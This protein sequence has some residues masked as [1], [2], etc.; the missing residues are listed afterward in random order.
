VQ[1]ARQT[2]IDFELGES[3]QAAVVEICRLLDGIPLAIELAAAWV[4]MLSF[5]EIAREI[6]ANI[7]F[8][9]TAARDVPERHRSLIASFDHSWQFL[10]GAERDSLCRLSIFEGGFTRQAAESVAG[11]K[12]DVLASLVS[13]SLVRRRRTGRYDMHEAIRQY[14][15]AR[16]GADAV[17]L[18]ST[19]DRHCEY[20]MGLVAARESALKSSDQQVAM[21]ELAAEMDNIRAAWYWGIQARK[22]SLLGASVRGL[23]W[24]FEVSGLL[25]EGIDQL[26][27]FAQQIRLDP[28]SPD[29]R[30]ALGHTLAQQALLFFRRGQF[31]RAVNCL[32]ESLS[33]LRAAD[34]QHMIPDPLVYLGAITHMSGDLNGSRLLFQEAL[35]CAQLHGDE[36]FAAYAIYNLGHIDSL[37]GRYSQGYERMME[38]LSIWH[39]LGDPYSI[40][41]GFNFL[42]WTWIKLGLFEEAEKSLEES[43]RLCRQ[44]GNRWGMG[45]AYRHIGQLKIAQGNY[46]EAEAFFRKGLE[47]FGDYTEGW[48]I[49]RSFIGLGEAA[50][51]QGHLKKAR[52]LYK[53]ALRLALELNSLPLIGEA[54]LG[55]AALD[56]SAGRWTDAWRG[57]HAVSNNPAV[58]HEIRERAQQLLQEVEQKVT[59]AQSQE[60]KDDASFK[61][62]DGLAKAWVL[63]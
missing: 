8:L 30:W 62:L 22:I 55:L 15:R 24:M 50:R 23:G 1:R 5:E 49:A 21:Q 63:N 18:D 40:T 37:D 34:Q 6:Q 17:A 2:R 39:R 9:S 38:G 45:T 59:G 26:E 11:T 35:A 19:S 27:P 48:D 58:V 29:S 31:D 16:F 12:L 56:A 32:E 47:T 54:L 41:L 52:V 20:Y 25:R 36:W 57:A 46:Q 53:G 51:L 3:D 10:S 14:A 44:T 28:T 7:S 4:G 42:I 43:L 60:W 13:K 61:T 33:L